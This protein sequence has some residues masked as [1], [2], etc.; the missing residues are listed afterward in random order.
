MQTRHFSEAKMNPA[1]IKID[2]Y[3]DIVDI[4]DLLKKKIEEAKRTLRSINE[5]KNKEDQEI[6]LWR[7]ELEDIEKRIELINGILGETQEV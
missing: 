3:K 5:L 2:E 4:I 6:N 1:Y 7:T